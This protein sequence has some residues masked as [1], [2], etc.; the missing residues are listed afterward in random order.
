M[1]VSRMFLFPTMV[2]SLLS[3]G[4]SQASGAD[5]KQSGTTSSIDS[6]SWRIDTVGNEYAKV[7]AYKDRLA[8]SKEWI[9]KDQFD[10]HIGPSLWPKFWDLKHLTFVPV[11]HEGF[12]SRDVIPQSWHGQNYQEY[13][14]EILADKHDYLVAT[15][16]VLGSPTLVLVVIT[17]PYSDYCRRAAVLLVKLS[18]ID[19]LGSPIIGAQG[20]VIHG[21]EN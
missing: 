11:H 18:E 2:V 20:G 9:G 3:L 4:A 15:G 7:A 6:V 14:Q 19:E 16:N 21:T 8:V 1:Q 10:T 13:A 17:K 5:C 12:G